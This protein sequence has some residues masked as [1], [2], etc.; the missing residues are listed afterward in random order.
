MVLHLARMGGSSMGRYA[1]HAYTP[2]SDFPDRLLTP[3]RDFF[4]KPYLF[5]GIGGSCG[6]FWRELEPDIFGGRGA[7]LRLDKL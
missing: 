6:D 2:C 5:L 1:N 3:Q 4:S 7:E